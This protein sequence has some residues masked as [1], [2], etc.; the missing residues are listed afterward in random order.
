[1][2]RTPRR[3]ASL[4]RSWISSG[5]TWS[6]RGACGGGNQS[7][8]LHLGPPTLVLHW[9]VGGHIV[10]LP[11]MFTKPSL[12]RETR[13][14]SWFLTPLQLAVSPSVLTWPS[15]SVTP[16][17]QMTSAP[18]SAPPGQ[19]VSP[20]PALASKSILSLQRGRPSK[21]GPALPA[22]PRHHCNTLPPA[23]PTPWD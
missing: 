4:A 13:K 21:M 1:M 5:N 14:E 15:K 12:A 22:L 9:A 3:E 10:H 18:F 11:T 7:P 20:K 23:P 19:E 2:D 6:G 16:P 17:Q 8:S